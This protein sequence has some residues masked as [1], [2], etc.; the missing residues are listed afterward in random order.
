MRLDYNNNGNSYPSAPQDSNYQ[1]FKLY[2]TADIVGRFIN[3]HFDELAFHEIDYK[4]EFNH[5]DPESGYFIQ[6][7][8]EIE[9]ENDADE[10]A[11][12][13][14]QDLTATKLF[15]FVEVSTQKPE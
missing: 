5:S 3:T 7:S 12:E 15:K 4:L 10:I 2:V 8:L 6:G 9:S 14:A 13:I 1:M 11:R